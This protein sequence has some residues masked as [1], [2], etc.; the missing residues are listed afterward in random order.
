M[1]AQRKYDYTPDRIL[2]EA[3]QHQSLRALAAALKIEPTAFVHHLRARP[4]LD[5]QVRGL[6]GQGAGPAYRVKPTVEVVG[7]DAF[8]TADPVELGDADRMMR[9]RGFNPDDWRL[10]GA[11]MTEWGRDP[12][13]GKP[14]QRLKIT[15]RRR[16]A[17][18]ALVIPEPVAA[19]PAPKRNAAQPGRAR[20]GFIVS[21]FHAP[22][23]DEAA[24]GAFLLFLRDTQPD[25][26]I[27]AGDVIDLPEPSRHRRNP[28]FHATPRQC[29]RSGFRDI[30]A[31]IRA[32]LPDADL[33]MLVG[34]HDVRLRNWCLETYPD[35]VDLRPGDQE[36]D[37]GATSLSMR[38]QLALDKLHIP[39]V[40]PVGE[41]ADGMI[42]V[43]RNLA[44]MH[45]ETTGKNASDT[46]LDKYGHSIAFGH[47]HRKRTVYKTQWDFDG[48]G[49]HTGVE[50]GCMCRVDGGLGYVR[51][52]NWQQGF[53]VVSVHPDG[54]FSLEHANFVNG[55]L[56]WRGERWKA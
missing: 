45:G 23:H 8:M 31:P 21:D 32:E 10:I 46:E 34:N 6:L 28:A 56:L 20:L 33:E 3:P 43:C 12:E 14:Y 1:A 30:L 29:V 24:V 51:R 26:G 41:Y 54:A 27:L 13:T 44:V 40:E 25:F 47:T 52:P 35:L 37:E 48:M 49:V 5:Q 42:A 55:E 19:I 11:S 9:D 36:D 18:A 22:F 2:A 39:I 7:D 50:V 15:L 53:G 16:L 4:D 38:T 17:A